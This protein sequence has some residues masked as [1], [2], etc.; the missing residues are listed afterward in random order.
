MARMID[1]DR[2][3]EGLKLHHQ[4]MPLPEP[5]R[6]NGKGTEQAQEDEKK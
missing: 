5:P 4:R 6:T 1:A 2:L 3:A